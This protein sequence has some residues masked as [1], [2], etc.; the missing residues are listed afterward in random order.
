MSKTPCDVPATQALSGHMSP[1]LRALRPRPGKYPQ[2]EKSV[3]FAICGPICRKAPATE[4][5]HRTA[6]TGNA[7][8]QVGPASRLSGHGQS[9]RPANRILRA[10]ARTH[11]QN[12]GAMKKDTTFSIRISSENLATIRQRA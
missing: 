8:L 3:P 11:F 6:G 4:K 12:G 2:L 9:P 5:R 7:H 1:F 10:E